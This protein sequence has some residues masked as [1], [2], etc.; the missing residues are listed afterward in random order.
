MS[1]IKAFMHGG[2]MKRSWFR[3]KS[4]F[5][6]SL[7]STFA[8]ANESLP[9][10]YIQELNARYDS[11][12]GLASASKVQ[13]EDFGDY[14]N[15]KMEVENYNGLLVFLF[16]DKQFELDISM[17][18]ITDAEQIDVAD[19]NFTN[20]DVEIDLSVEGAD[21]FDPTFRTNVRDAKFNCLRE[22]QYEDIKDDLLSACLSNSDIT[23]NQAYF[24]SE[25]SEF[26]SVLN[27][28]EILG[29]AFDLEDLVIRINEG[30]LKAQFKSSLSKGVK[31]KIE[32]ETSYDIQNK[33]VV[34]NLKKAKASFF[35]IKGTIFKE[36]ES[37]QV[38]G[39]EVD[40]PYIYFSFEE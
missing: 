13:I 26:Y 15:P 5:L 25:T 11:P 27:N 28:E 30:E 16:E 40:R 17:L 23:L 14:T 38:E 36:L 2:T 29:D 12:S 34:V 19:L 8:I 4:I 24:K 22:S 37:M 18:G 32:A 3:S 39:L 10:G 21:A 6:V 31:I 20:N 9:K 35:N 33:R 1:S 7:L